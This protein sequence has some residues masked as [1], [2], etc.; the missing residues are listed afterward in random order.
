M[1]RFLLRA[2][3]LLPLAI[4]SPLA[5]APRAVASQPLLAR[6][7]AALLAAPDLAQAHWGISVTTLDGRVLYA[8]NDAQLFAP[9]SN[10]KLCT[11][12]AALA[13]LGPTARPVTRVLANG[14]IDAQG[15]LRGDL[16][17]QGNG[18]ATLSGR[19]YPY[20]LHT[21][22]PVAPLAAL[23][24]LADQVAQRGLRVVA[25]NVI[26]D[27]TAFPD[28]RYG[29]GWAWDDLT[30]GYGAP[31]SALTIN[32]NAVYLNVFPGAHTGDPVTAIWNPEEAGSYYMLENSARTAGAQPALG[33]DRQPGS[34][35]VRLFGTLP[36]TSAGKH[37]A[38]AI[39][40]PA[41]FAAIVFRQMLQARGVRI[42]GQALALHR[43]ST[44]AEHFSAE[45]RAPVS[46]PES[47]PVR[48]PLRLAP[49]PPGAAVLAEHNSVPPLED[50]T[51]TNKASQNLHAELLLRLLGRQYGLDGS[52][53]QGTRVVRQFLLNAG[54]NPED[55]FFYDGSGMS[56]QDLI[57][58][59]A[60]TQLLRYAAAQSWGAEFRSTLPVGGVDGSLAGRFLRTPLQ[61][62]VFAKT[63]TLREVTG[64]SGYVRARSGK[65][66]AVAILCNAHR[67]DAKSHTGEA[68]AVAAIDSIL[69]AIAA[70]N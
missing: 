57:A 18:D 7:I 21:E 11:T 67:P 42:M 24:S 6:R 54:V 38:L 32:D 2:V 14:A 68:N 53:A 23:E 37:Y 19:T 34:K 55:F 41:E 59:R 52:A 58:P 15:V 62:R 69:A 50:I 43:P 4:T 13:L 12:A 29:S 63:G 46:L 25:G 65:M 28:E 60:L 45:Q 9:A 56:T 64:L 44:D 20:Q 8:K 16:I 17:L 36:I 49:A 51:V 31:V 1:P 48:A 40:D 66:L 35:T 39:E 70:A 47:L 3:L 10:A 33:V 26:G 61:G 22:R 5:A 27:D 30:W